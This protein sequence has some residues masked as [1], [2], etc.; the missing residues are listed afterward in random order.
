MF[1]GKKLEARFC[2]I[3][4]ELD[5]LAGACE[6]SA[7]EALEDLNAELEDALLLFSELKPT[8]EDWREE[9]AGALE[10]ILALAEDYRALAKDV[11]GIAEAAQSLEA[12]AN[13]ALG[14]LE[15]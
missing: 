4:D 7:A 12:A 15:Q 6:G 2:E 8:D 9:C 13:T 14:G 11:P 5:D 3:L 10:T 1:P